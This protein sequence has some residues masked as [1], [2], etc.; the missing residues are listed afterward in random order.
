MTSESF[1]TTAPIGTSS[2]SSAARAS[3]RAKRIA[4]SSVTK[5]EAGFRLS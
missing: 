4:S 3:S 5:M 1:T 2:C